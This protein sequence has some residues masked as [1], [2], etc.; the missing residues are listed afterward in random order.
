MVVRNPKKV[1]IRSKIM[2]YVFIKYTYNS[3][4]YLF[5]IHKSSIGGIPSN[6]IMKSRNA[7]FLK[8]CFYLKKHKKTIHLK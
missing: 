8:M 2:N 4:A 7:I 5:I 6:T 3:T 1:K